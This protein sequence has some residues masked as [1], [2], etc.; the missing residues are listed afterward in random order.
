[1]LALAGKP[2]VAPED[3]PPVA[4]EDLPPVELTV[5]DLWEVARREMELLG[6]PISID[7]L[8]LLGIDDEGHAIDWTRYVPVNQLDQYYGCRVTVCGIMIADRINLT[9]RGDL[10]KFVSLADR[11]GVVE[12]FLFPETYRRFGHLTASNPILAATGI[13]EPF[14]NHNGFNLRIEHVAPPARTATKA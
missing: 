11:T 4:P 14:E 7:P 5:P 2:P 10:M 9:T 3:L 1:V 8:T 13:V 6:F 12:T